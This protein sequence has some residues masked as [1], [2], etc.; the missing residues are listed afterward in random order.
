MGAGSGTEGVSVQEK[1]DH[2]RTRKTQTTA[3]F[4]L[5]S[6]R[7]LKWHLASDIWGKLAMA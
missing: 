7:G 6:L 5:A 1:G 4:D 3:P 2:P